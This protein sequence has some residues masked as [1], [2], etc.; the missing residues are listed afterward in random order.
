MR[1]RTQA[2]HLVFA[3]PMTARELLV[4]DISSRIL[5]AGIRVFPPSFPFG[6]HHDYYRTKLRIEGRHARRSHVAS[7]LA[8]WAATRENGDDYV[9]QGV[10][11]GLLRHFSDAPAHRERL[12]ADIAARMEIL[13]WGKVFSDWASLRISPPA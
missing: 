10:C 6:M 3:S 8:E 5:D 2:R 1:T 11:G 12:P 13:E 4:R 9:W 7:A